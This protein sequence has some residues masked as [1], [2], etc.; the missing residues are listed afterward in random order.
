MTNLWFLSFS[1]DMRKDSFLLDNVYLVDASLQ[2]NNL[3]VSYLDIFLSDAAMLN[4]CDV[5]CLG[6]YCT[7][8]FCATTTR[9]RVI[10]QDGH[11]EGEARHA[12][13]ISE[14]KL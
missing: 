2:K 4:N 10:I 9:Q 5:L 8:P 11:S 13:G 6:Y 1:K 3:K 14:N 7:R 12:D